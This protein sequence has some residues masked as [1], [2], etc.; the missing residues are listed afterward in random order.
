M[1]C[2]VQ[3]VLIHHSQPSR[4]TLLGVLVHTALLWQEACFHNPGLH[5]QTPLAVTQQLLS[6]G[7]MSPHS[8]ASAAA[9][10]YQL[11]PGQ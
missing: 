3:A 8:A 1:L 6:L 7:A 2:L 4:C 9:Y 10:A 11:K 5:L